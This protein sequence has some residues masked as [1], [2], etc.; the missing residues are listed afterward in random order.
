MWSLNPRSHSPNGLH[1]KI[2]MFHVCSLQQFKLCSTKKLLT[3]YGLRFNNFS[4]WIWEQ[5]VIWSIFRVP[6][7]GL[8]SDKLSRDGQIFQVWPYLNSL[9]IIKLPLSQEEHVQIFPLS[10]P[11]QTCGLPSDFVLERDPKNIFY[12]QRN[13]ENYPDQVLNFLLFDRHE[14]IRTESSGL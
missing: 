14:Y 13:K 12:Y 8:Q 10:L 9:I 5:N 1:L 3:K 7:K 6:L 2:Y 11:S 4:Y